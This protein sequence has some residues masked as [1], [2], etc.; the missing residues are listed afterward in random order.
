MPNYIQP[1]LS[2]KSN[3]HV[4]ASVPGPASI[5]MNLTVSDQ[6][7]V[8]TLK[9][10]I[11]STS[12]T[13]TKFADGSV[14]AE[15][16]GAA[17]DGNSG[18]TPGTVGGFV[19][20]KN[21]S[22][23]TGEYIQVAIVSGQHGGGTNTPTAPTGATELDEADHETL[24]TMTLQPGEFAWFPWDYTG[25]LYWKAAASKTPQLEYWIFDRG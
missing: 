5:V 11:L 22:A 21:N 23:T 20:L 19:Y 9:H 12:D 6:L 15:A 18:L 8:D 2:F 24:R 17:A 1:T 7:S 4:V 16:G 14:L 3:S 25:D 13:T 10:A